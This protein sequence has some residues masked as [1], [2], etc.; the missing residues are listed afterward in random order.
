MRFPIPG[1]PFCFDIADADWEFSDMDT[2]QRRNRFYVPSREANASNIEFAIVDIGCIEPDV[3]R[4]AT[5]PELVKARIVPVLLAIRYGLQLPPVQLAR[6]DSGG[7]R[8]F[9]LVN[10]WHRYCA[11]IAAGFEQIPAV[12]HPI[13][14]TRP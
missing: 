12:F 5:K 3:E 1:S 9:Q 4:I 8:P 6:V 7:G 2:F 14:W 11:S 10:G 13:A